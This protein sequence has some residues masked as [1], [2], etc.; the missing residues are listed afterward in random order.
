MGFI[1]FEQTFLLWCSSQIYCPLPE[2]TS[3]FISK[4]ITIFIQTCILHAYYNL[5]NTGYLMRE[6]FI[7]TKI[8]HSQSHRVYTYYLKNTYIYFI[9]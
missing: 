5:K 8:S 4:N 7:W 6:Q 1:I 2:K 9:F 3:F